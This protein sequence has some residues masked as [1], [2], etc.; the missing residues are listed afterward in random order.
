M[1]VPGVQFP[2]AHPSGAHLWKQPERL[3]SASWS[4][5]CGGDGFLNQLL[6]IDPV[7]AF[8][9]EEKTHTQKK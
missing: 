7:S 2:D 5:F 6:R 3:H 4:L 9:K 8:S 1:P